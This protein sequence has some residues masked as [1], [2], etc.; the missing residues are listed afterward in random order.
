[1]G[2]EF[3]VP[4]SSGRPCLASREL[5]RQVREQLEI[6]ILR[7][8]V[9]KDYVHIRVFAP[10]EVAPSEI[11]RRIKGRTSSKICEKFPLVK[12]RCWERHAWARGYFCI[13]ADELAKGTRSYSFWNFL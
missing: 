10:P 12:K 8:V 11:M 1:M 13:T 3:P 7:E 9:S 4:S 2:N 6:Q 5:V